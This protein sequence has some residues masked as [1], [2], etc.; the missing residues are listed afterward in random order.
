MAT[1]SGPDHQIE[2]SRISIETGVVAQ[3]VGAADQELY[4]VANKELHNALV[5]CC[6][7]VRSHL[8]PRA[9]WATSGSI[10]N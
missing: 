7:F 1:S 5:E 3:S 6:P 10:E 2:I 9:Q 8:L 4:S